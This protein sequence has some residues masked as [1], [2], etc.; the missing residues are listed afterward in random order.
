M[1]CGGSEQLMLRFRSWGGA[2]PGAGRKRQR[3]A[4][5]APHV[6]RPVHHARHPVHLTLR[7]GSGLPSL[8]SQV[9]GGLIGRTIRST[10]RRWFRVIH[11]SIQS[12]H[13]HL[14]V[15]A[16]DRKALSRGSGALTIR[17]ARRL[18]ALL[19]RRGTVFPERYRERPLK[20]PREVRNALVYVLMNAHKHNVALN[21]LDPHSS[22]TTFD[23]WRDVSIVAR[24][25]PV[26]SHLAEMGPSTWLL[27]RGWRNHG[28]IGS[29]ERPGS[30]T[31]AR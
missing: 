25:S 5:G 18:N 14:L 29:W 30:G 6:A 23:A 10:W 20:T 16:D 26:G 3:R 4:T 11:F 22:A 24:A 17:I 2:R 12:N 27:A 19:A 9:I 7:L 1:S 31:P 15:E 21:G 8:R 13:L 28:L